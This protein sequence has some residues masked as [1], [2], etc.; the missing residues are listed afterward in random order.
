MGKWEAF[1]PVVG[2]PSAAFLGASVGALTRGYGRDVNPHT[3]GSA[4]GLDTPPRLLGTVGT[5]PPRLF[6]FHARIVFR[7]FPLIQEVLT[8]GPTYEILIGLDR[9]SERMRQPDRSYQNER[10]PCTSN[11]S[12]RY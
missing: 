6:A 8:M 7:V 4:Y 11:C 10:I 12:E 5:T 9:F 1:A 2:P 3:W